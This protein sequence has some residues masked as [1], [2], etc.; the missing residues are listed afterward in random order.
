MRLVSLSYQEAQ[1]C[2]SA[3][4]FFRRE[5]ERISKQKAPETLKAMAKLEKKLWRVEYK[6]VR[7][8]R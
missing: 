5:Y 7:S 4:S 2:L 8:K 3:I 1:D 6:P